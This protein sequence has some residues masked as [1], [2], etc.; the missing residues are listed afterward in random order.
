MAQLRIWLEATRW[1]LVARR[2]PSINKLMGPTTP[3][4]AAMATR[5]RSASCCHPK[6]LLL[7]PSPLL[8]PPRSP[9]PSPLLPPP[10]SPSSFFFL[11]LLFL[12]C[13][14]FLRLLRCLYPPCQRPAPFPP[15]LPT[16]HGPPPSPPPPPAFPLPPLR[17][18]LLPPPA[19]GPIIPPVLLLPPHPTPPHPTPLHSSSIPFS[20]LDVQC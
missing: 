19:P 1:S 17:R 5:G 13:L 16:R 11:L 15:S 14:H 12:L 7:R 20:C 4:T 10:A 9:S 8:P 3:A 18:L 6:Q 2:P